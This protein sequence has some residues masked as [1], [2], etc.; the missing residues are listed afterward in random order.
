[1]QENNLRVMKFYAS[2]AAYYELSSVDSS[3]CFVVRPPAHLAPFR[4]L[5]RLGERTKDGATALAKN[6]CTRKLSEHDYAFAR[7]LLL[8]A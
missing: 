1:M 5:V 4:L 2:T 3:H 6:I 8:S 7:L